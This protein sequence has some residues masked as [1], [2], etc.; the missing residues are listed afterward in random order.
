M[1]AVYGFFFE[2]KGIKNNATSYS[3]YM[4]VRGTEHR[5]GASPKR[6]FNGQLTGID[7]SLFH[8]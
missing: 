6:P 7:E 5:T 1:I 8:N 2:I 4:Q 3:F